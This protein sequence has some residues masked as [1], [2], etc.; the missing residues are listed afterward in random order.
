MK[1]G[2]TGSRRVPQTGLTRQGLERL[3]EVC[4]V[5][6][7]CAFAQEEGG[8]LRSRTLLVPPGSVIAQGLHGRAMA[9][10]EARLAELALADGQNALEEIDIIAVETDHF[11]TAHPGHRQQAQ[12]R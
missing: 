5:D 3:A 12:H 1:E 10:V 4:L 9:E 11:A 6:S 8:G 2:S 7:L